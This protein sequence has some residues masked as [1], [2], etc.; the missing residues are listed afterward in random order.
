MNYSVKSLHIYPIKSLQGIQL[1]TV[2]LVDYGFQ[3]DRQWMLVDTENKFISQ[4]TVPNMITL[5]PQISGDKLLVHGQ[6]NQS[7][8]LD[9]NNRSNSNIEV[10]IWKDTV[11]ASLEDQNINDWFSQQLG[12]TCKLV[13]LATKQDRFVDDNF[14]KNKETVGFADGFP[15]LVVSHSNIELLNSKLDTPVDMNRFRPNIVIDGLAAHEEDKLQSI[16]INNIEIKLV[17]PCE[18]CQVP[19]I[20]QQT[21]EKRGDILRSL[22]KYRQFNKR[23]YFGM[24]GLHQ[25]NG[26]IQVGQA[27]QVID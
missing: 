10:S 26:V 1:N 24:N 16:I 19:S 22:I 11:H 9:L 3:Y 7:I 2:T 15:L 20:D 14:A 25:S 13:K 6:N 21:G 12:I 17:K 5:K 4:R 8:Q 27:I 18:R 23:I